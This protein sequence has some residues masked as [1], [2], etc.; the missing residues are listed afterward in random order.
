MYISILLLYI[1]MV[2]VLFGFLFKMYIFILL[3]IIYIK[4]NPFIKTTDKKL[5]EVH[6]LH[7][8]KGTKR[9]VTD[10]KLIK[11]QVL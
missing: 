6:V 9:E 11:I 5:K 7:Q 8:S 10:K 1:Q 4:L 3:Y 2:F